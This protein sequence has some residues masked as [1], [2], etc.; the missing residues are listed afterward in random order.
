[1]P[2][3]WK[4]RPLSRATVEDGAPVKDEKPDPMP[5]V[6]EEFIAWLRRVPIPN[7]FPFETQTGEQALKQMGLS[8]GVLI[9]KTKIYLHHKSNQ[10]RKTEMTV[11]APPQ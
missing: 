2:H 3:N 6:S 10:E 1:L 4:D 5:A 7:V 9:L 8:Q 11:T